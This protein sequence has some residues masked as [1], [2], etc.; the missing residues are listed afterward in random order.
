MQ[1]IPL[2]VSWSGQL[3]RDTKIQPFPLSLPP[4]ARYGVLQLRIAAGAA[5]STH[6]ET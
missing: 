6:T 1:I 5:S 4:Y 2:L 3:V